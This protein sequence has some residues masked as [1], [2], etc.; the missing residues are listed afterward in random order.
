MTVRDLR[1]RIAIVDC[2][3]RIGL[4]P[5]VPCQLKALLPQNLQKNE[6]YLPAYLPAYLPTCTCQ[7]AYLPTCPPIPAYLPN[8]PPAYLPTCFT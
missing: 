1:L 2:E 4:G 6:I 8:C 7:P 5:M 3:V